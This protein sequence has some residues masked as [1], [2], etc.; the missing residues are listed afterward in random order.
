VSRAARCHVRGG[1]AHPQSEVRIGAKQQEILEPLVVNFHMSTNI[2]CSLF[3]F[4]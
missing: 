1:L 4:W 3:S 2:P